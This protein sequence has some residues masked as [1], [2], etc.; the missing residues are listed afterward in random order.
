MPATPSYLDSPC[1]ATTPLDPFSTEFSFDSFDHSLS[2]PFDLSHLQVYSADGT[3]AFDQHCSSLDDGL[4]VSA[5]FCQFPNDDFFENAKPEMT[6][7]G[8]DFSAFLASFA[9]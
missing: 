7:L 2:K 5:D 3:C 8:M 1:S 4:Y 9:M 6:H